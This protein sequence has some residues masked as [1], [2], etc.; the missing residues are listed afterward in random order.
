M[1]SLVWK[2][3]KAKKAYMIHFLSKESC[4]QVNTGTSV[5][6]WCTYAC[7]W[8]V[9]KLLHDRGMVSVAKNHRIHL[10]LHTYKYHKTETLIR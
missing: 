6:L 4:L 8:L 5:F 1:F 9:T 10:E 3:A 2:D 7:R